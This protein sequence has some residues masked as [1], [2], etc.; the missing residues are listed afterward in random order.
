MITDLISQDDGKTIRWKSGNNVVK[1]S[2]SHA[3][4]AALLDDINCVI[5]VEP[6]ECS[7]PDNAVIYDA[8]GIFV[9][10][11]TN[12]CLDKGPVCF[13]SVYSSVGDIILV[14]VCARVFYEC[15]LDKKKRKFNW[16]F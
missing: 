2:Y 15:R 11:F 1:K 14:S 10:R 8:G 7:Y 5:V 6:D 13:D 3:S 4:T 9:R 12:P 16:G